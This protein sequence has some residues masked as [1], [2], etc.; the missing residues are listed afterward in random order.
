[1]VSSCSIR[2]ERYRQ[3]VLDFK[4]SLSTTV[5]LSL[6]PKG[7]AVAKNSQSVILVTGATGNVGRQVVSQLLDTGA[8]VRALTRDPDS[9]GLPDGVDVV[10]GDLSV[11]DT[12]N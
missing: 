5:A 1:M 10:R 9:A 6:K 4:Q 2:N 8:A 7:I 11:P 3:K 12:L